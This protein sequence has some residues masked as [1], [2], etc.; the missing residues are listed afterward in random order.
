[1]P[2][3]ITTRGPTRGREYEVEDV[4]IL[5][6]SP[7]C[8][9][10]IGDLTVSRQH[11]RI[12]RT[13]RGFI[14]EDLGSGNGTWVNDSRVSQHL[15]Q[16]EDTIRI[17]ECAFRFVEEQERSGEGRWVNMVTVVA[18]SEHNLISTNT[19]PRIKFFDTQLNAS[20]EEIRDDLSRAHRM[21]EALYNATNATSS[22][23]EPKRL[24]NK[25]LDYLLVVFPN[26]ELGYIMLL[27]DKNQLVPGAIRRQRGREGRSARGLVIS[28]SVISQVMH[29]G[30]AVLSAAKGE[31]DT[32]SDT[33]PYGGQASKMCSPLRAQ[34]KTHGILHIEGTPGGRAFTQEDLDLLTGIA[35]IAGISIVNASLHERLMKQQRLEQDLRFAKRVQ[36]SFLPLE[37]PEVPGFS[38][39]RR[40]N[41]L[42][43]VGGDF[44]DFIRLPDDRIG[45]T[46]GDVSGK[47]VSAALLMARLTSDIRYFAMSEHDPSSVLDRANASLIRNLQDNMFATVLYL[48]L[49]PGGKLALSNAGHI[50][51]LVRRKDG[52]VEQIDDATNLALGV[53]ADTVFDQ[54][55]IQLEVGDSV[56]L[57]T[58]GLVEAKNAIGEEFGLAH[59]ERSVKGAS[60]QQL[61]DDI[62]RD[63][64]HFTGPVAQYDDLTLVSFTRVA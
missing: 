22:T 10:Y 9:I 54:S 57:C 28:Q 5:G 4:C 41:P 31:R 2:K 32:L 12:V 45:V 7:S 1:V 53:L 18:G 47:G 16:N 52:T 58:D 21:L 55:F 11:A 43:E 20:E 34:G 27:D 44:Y 17:S 30:K 24:F 48:T 42:Y 40:Y 51:P 6:R 62:L 59:L 15:L 35:R 63:L 3:L 50:P 19:E 23:L 38:F 49:E 33:N 29:E 39:G 36:Q 64:T 46:I 25:I 8:Q 13:A 56:L 14:I 61:L 37:P 60:P 26:A